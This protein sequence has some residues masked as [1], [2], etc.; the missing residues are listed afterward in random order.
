MAT[1]ISKV[2]II[3]DY[4]EMDSKETMNEYK[5]LDEAERL[6][7]ARGAAKHMGLAQDQCDF[8]LS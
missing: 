1:K 2:K 5:K 3:K 6:E 8:P 4:F 7:L